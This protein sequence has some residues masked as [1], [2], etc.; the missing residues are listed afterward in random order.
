MLNS[1]SFQLL[2]SEDFLLLSKMSPF[3][4]SFGLNEQF[5]ASEI[6]FRNEEFLPDL[7]R[8]G[9]VTVCLL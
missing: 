8:I 1:S 2:S 7:R 3:E 6:L 9:H 5:G 4:L